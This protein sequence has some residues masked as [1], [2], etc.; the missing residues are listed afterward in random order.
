MTDNVFRME[1]MDDGRSNYS[2]SSR[3]ARD[4]DVDKE[5]ALLIRTVT[6]VAENNPNQSIETIRSNQ[7]TALEHM[8]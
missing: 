1:R 2:G 6:S 3:S 7:A 4:R 8:V 5:V